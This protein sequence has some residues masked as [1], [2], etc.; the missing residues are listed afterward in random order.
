MVGTDNNCVKLEL[1]G[2]L[3][4]IG[5][6]GYGPNIFRR[7]FEVKFKQCNTLKDNEIEW[8]MQD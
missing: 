6:L 8:I 4:K 2:M 3:C 1:K 7:Y 5:F